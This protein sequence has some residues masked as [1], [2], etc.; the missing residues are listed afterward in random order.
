MTHEIAPRRLRNRPTA[1][2]GLVVGAAAL[3][4]GAVGCGSSVTGDDGGGGSGECGGF[5]D[6][7][8]PAPCE[9]G[10]QTYEHGESIPGECGGCSC[11]DGEVLCDDVECYVGS[12][13]HNG[14]TYQEGDSF[15]AGDGC[16]TCSCT[17]GNVACTAAYCEGECLY[18]GVTYQTG[19]TFP[20][21][22][23][24]NTCTC[25]AGGG[26]SCTEIACACDPES[27]WWR[28]YVSLDPNEC[29]VIDY[30]CP[31]NTTGFSNACGCGCEQSAECPEWFDCMPPSPCD[32]Q[33]I[34]IDCP[35]SG[36]AY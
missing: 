12:C 35:Y 7:Y 4:L 31:E 8:D 16:N 15:P 25:E 3:V 9:Y 19:D 11:S 10:G 30:A 1:L 36:I 29:A 27:E 17:D 28:E 21:I 6:C 20:S 32:P 22:D 24:C 14:Q 33:Q 26:V 2:G 23:D 13:E 5:T 34:A 18:E